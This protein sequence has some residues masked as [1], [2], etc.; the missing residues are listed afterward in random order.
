MY[1]SNVLIWICNIWF[2]RTFQ[3]KHLFNDVHRLRLQAQG[4]LSLGSVGSD[5]TVSSL[6][7]GLDLGSVYR[8]CSKIS[9]EY[10]V[11]QCL[12]LFYVKNHFWTF[13]RGSLKGHDLDVNQKLKQQILHMR[14]CKFSMTCNLSHFFKL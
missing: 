3:V 14:K 1:K 13:W 9:L 5:S 11:I 6:G 4:S 12:L 10:S 8:A 2:V 7:S